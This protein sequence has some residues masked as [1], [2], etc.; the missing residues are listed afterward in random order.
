[1]AI[2]TR[3][4]PFYK[5]FLTLT[6]VMALQNVIVF[7]VNLADNIMLGAFDETALSGVALVN[8]I[9]FLLQMIV[10]G[11]GNGMVVLAA[12]YWGRKETKPIERITGIGLRIGLG[13]AVLMWGVTLFWPRQVLGLLTPETAV[14]EEGVKYLRI[15]CF[16]YIFFTAT[17]I[18]LATLRSVETVKIGFFISFSTLLIN[19]CLNYILIFGHFGAPRLGVRGAA[20]ATLTARIVEFIIM[21]VYLRFFDKK[22]RIGFQGLWSRDRELFRAYLRVGLPTIG[23]SASW[24][25]AMGI[26]TGILGRLGA[27]VIAANSIATTVFQIVSVVASASSSAASVIVGKTIGEG[28]IEAVKEYA[29]TLQVVFIMIGAITGLVLLI[30]KDFIIDFYNISAE[31]RALALQFM[32]VLSITVVGTSYQMPALVGIVGGGGETSFVLINDL[33]FMWCIVLPASAICAFALE[34]SPVWVFAC[35][36]SDQVVKCFVAIVKVNRYRW[37]RHFKV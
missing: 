33:I 34:L 14:I 25:I 23:S 5:M 22:I 29:K 32:T 31:T 37:I 21:A 36:K 24:G 35:L 13:V 6:T 16:S 28:R 7:S 1:M 27:S 4:K 12:R 10:G 8:Q 17:N 30:G 9:Q 18:L 2:L 26:Q 15:I 11:V 19:I 20:I 3:E